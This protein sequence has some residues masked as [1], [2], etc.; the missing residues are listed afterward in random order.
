M[1]IK[2]GEKKNSEGEETQLF[3]TGPKSGWTEEWMQMGLCA[4]GPCSAGCVATLCTAG[5][6]GWLVLCGFAQL[7]EHKG[8]YA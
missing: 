1:V 5:D 7:T 6:E 3:A 4:A 2:V 8:D